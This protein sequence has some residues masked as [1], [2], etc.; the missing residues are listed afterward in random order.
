MKMSKRAGCLALLVSLLIA[1]PAPAKDAYLTDLAGGLTL[2]SQV[3]GEV[4]LDS[5]GGGLRL[6]FGRH[7]G[8]GFWLLGTMGWAHVNGKKIA[9]CAGCIQTQT[10]DS[11]VAGLGF[12]YVLP[13][14]DMEM[15]LQAGFGYVIDILDREEEDGRD[16]PVGL[17]GQLAFAGSIG[18]GFEIVEDVQVGFKVDTLLGSHLDALSLGCYTGLRY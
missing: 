10:A 7:V 17:H 3:G 16:H 1:A 2:R 13:I 6:D 8:C 14:P 12:R 18:L 15:F 11:L 9:E 4:E 5:P